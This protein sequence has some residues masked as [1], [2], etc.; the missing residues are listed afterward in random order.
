MFK[1]RKFLSRVALLILLAVAAHKAHAQIGVYG[2]L[3][4]IKISN[5]T[6]AQSTTFGGTNAGY[7]TTGGTLGAYYDFLR[8]GPVALGVDVRGQLASK[9]K[10]GLVGLRLAA[11]PP[12]LPFKP[13]IAGYVGVANRTNIYNAAS[14]D[15][16]WQVASGL[17]YTLIPHIDFRAIE[18]GVGQISTGITTAPTGTPSYFTISSG[19]TVHF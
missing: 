7:W 14:S 6:S 18:V 10:L 8:L 1:L 5:P 19:I 17:D 12:V 15:L 2:T 16:A 4:A 3:T 11:H 13:Y 9:A